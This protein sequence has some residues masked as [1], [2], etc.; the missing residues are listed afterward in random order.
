MK[1][2]SKISTMKNLFFAT[3]CI[4]SFS[5]KAQNPPT[6]IAD[7]LQ[8]I[9]D[10]ALPTN[11]QKSGAVMGIIVPGQWTWFGASG[12]AI[13]GV[14]AGQAETTALPNNQFRVGSITK[15]MLATCIL[16]LEQNGLL[17]INDPIS[18]YLRS[19]LVNDTIA[20][21]GTVLIRHL[22]NHTSGIGNSGD[23]TACQTDVLTNPTAFKSLEEA[24]Y[25]GASLGETFEPG[26]AWA[27]SNTN[28]SIL[29][30]ILENI[31]GMSYE[32]YLQQTIISP[33]GLQNTL[34]PTSSQIQNAHIGCYWNIGSWIDL[35][36]IN[37]SIY[38]GWADV[39]S[40][41]EDLMHFY[42]ALTN[43]EI[44]NATELAVMHTIDAASYDYGMGLDFYTISGFDYIGHYGEVANTSGLFRASISSSLAPNGYYIAYNFNT[45]GVDMQN[46]IDVPIL[47]LL[48]NSALSV[49]E[50][51]KESLNQIL[52]YP[53]PVKEELHLI[54][55][56][57]YQDVSIKWIDFTGKIV[58][59]ENYLQLPNLMDMT[60][61]K[62]E[63]GCYLLEIENSKYMQ[64]LILE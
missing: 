47:Q 1:N 32:E 34:I 17:S 21:S 3:F 26:F 54:F 2:L 33:L 37:P 49:S 8:Y 64:K 48:N 40:T 30:M 58:L 52:F 13:A 31:T 38:K 28:Y 62:L 35:T 7:S 60:S 42:Q 55:D 36:I 18:M 12:N 59:H 27:Y 50:N 11:F 53:N 10:H 63:K 44:I 15:T 19:T 22:L 51:S 16:K 46:K 5:S 9:L 4:F 57:K 23:N 24:I 6:F 56:N 43:L 61:K 25:C 14:T 45:Q 39:V 41:T 29:A 20:S